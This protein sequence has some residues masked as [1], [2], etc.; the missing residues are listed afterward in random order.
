MRT[1]SVALLALAGLAAAIAARAA[2]GAA[3]AAAPAEPE[4]PEGVV[5]GRFEARAHAS[6]PDRPVIA[7]AAFADRLA[8]VPAPDDLRLLVGSLENARGV[9]VVLRTG[10]FQ[11]DRDGFAIRILP[12]AA[13]EV[14]VSGRYELRTTGA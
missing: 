9:P 4:S 6:G 14:V 11:P 10:G 1:R 5:S 3:P 2:R 12:S 8:A 13:G 7:A